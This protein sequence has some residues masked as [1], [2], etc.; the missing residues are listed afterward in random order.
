MQSSSYE[1]KNG[2][3]IYVGST[4]LQNGGHRQPTNSARRAGTAG[5]SGV[6]G[7]AVFSSIGGRA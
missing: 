6:G 4:P 3:P 7:M 5:S 1:W 2:M